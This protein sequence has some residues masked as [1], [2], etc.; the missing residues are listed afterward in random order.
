[1]LLFLTEAQ[2]YLTLQNVLNFDDSAFYYAYLWLEEQNQYIRINIL[3][4]LKQSTC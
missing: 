3:P 4:L 1:M 2:V